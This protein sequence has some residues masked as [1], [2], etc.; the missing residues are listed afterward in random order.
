MCGGGVQQ[1]EGG[2]RDVELE[3]LR[4][5]MKRE[6]ARVEDD[7]AMAASVEGRP[8]SDVADHQKSLLARL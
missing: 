3:C 8:V 2:V 4:G 6:I 1:P 7:E 5:L